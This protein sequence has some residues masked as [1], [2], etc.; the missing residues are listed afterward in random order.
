V[1]LNRELI[2]VTGHFCALRFVFLQLS[3]K[4]VSVGQCV[5]VRLFR[6]RHVGRLPAFL[7]SQIHS[8][9]GSIRYQRSFAMLA[10]K[11]DVGIGRDFAERMFRRFHGRE[12]SR[13][14]AA[15][16]AEIPNHRHQTQASVKTLNP[17][18]SKHDPANILTFGSLEFP[19]D[20]EFWDL[21][22]RAAKLRRAGPSESWPKGESV[23][24][25]LELGRL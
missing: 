17:K 22:L 9:G 16:H 10:M 20:L 23:T 14:C 11:E 12:T 6:L 13:G 8:R 18:D 7:A 4:F 3:A 5:R 15:A 25:C 24:A 19:W 2:D 21:E 1:Q